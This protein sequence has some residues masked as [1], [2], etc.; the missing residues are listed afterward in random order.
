MDNEI[1]GRPWPCTKQVFNEFGFVDSNSFVSVL[2]VTAHSLIYRLC[3]A[4]M[5]TFSAWVVVLGALYVDTHGASRSWLSGW[6]RNLSYLSHSRPYCPIWR[7]WRSTVARIQFL[8]MSARRFRLPPV[9]A[10][11]AFAAVRE[12]ILLQRG[13]E[14]E[15]LRE[16]TPIP[17]EAVAMM[18]QVVIG[19]L[20]DKPLVSIISWHVIKSSARFDDGL[21]VTPPTVVLRP[22]GLQCRAW[23]TKTDRSRRGTQ[24][25]VC[26][27]RRV[28]E[29]P[30]GS[31]MGSSV[32]SLTHRWPTTGRF[33]PL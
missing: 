2:S 10:D 32:G 13:S 29:V 5:E 3:L 20:K 22:E 23:Q 1:L 31:G 8:P 24:L 26:R 17:L 30:S 27:A 16:A 21:H 33:L 9:L 4:T 19:N 6:A 25:V 18:E 11:P 14:A 12:R 28:W 15:A 7:S